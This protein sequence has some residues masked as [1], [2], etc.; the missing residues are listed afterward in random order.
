MQDQ[1]LTSWPVGRPGMAFGFGCPK[2]DVQMLNQSPAAKNVK[3]ITV[4]TAVGSATTYSWTLLSV[5]QSVRTASDDKAVIA[6]LIRDRILND[7]LTGGWFESVVAG[8]TLVTL[9]YRK[10]GVTFALA[11]TDSNLA[12]AV[13]TAA[14]AAAAVPFGAVVLRDLSDKTNFGLARLS[15]AAGVG[16]MVMKVTPAH[17]NTAVYTVVVTFNGIPYT[18][19][20]VSDSSATVDEIVDGLV[21]LLNAALPANSVLAAADA[22]TATYLLLTSEIPGM[23]FQVSVGSNI[24]TALMAVAR[25]DTYGP[26]ADINNL[27]AGVA[28]EDARVP[29]DVGT[30]SLS[31]P[32]GT[33]MTVRRKGLVGVLVQDGAVEI[34]DEVWVGIGS[35]HEGLV[36]TTASGANYAKCNVLQWRGRAGTY[37]GV[38][39]GVLEVKNAA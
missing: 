34:D 23:P 18:A 4:S 36:R 14:A 7:P 13:V 27:I 10:P 26:A 35:G 32:G 22:D 24:A 2:E 19:S 11:T 39:L 20:L 5:A 8:A 31:Y 15:A 1:V 33:A 37:G 21:T 38:N 25:V 3:T 29:G 9:T 30:T 16:A 28:L 17:I 12:V 6:A